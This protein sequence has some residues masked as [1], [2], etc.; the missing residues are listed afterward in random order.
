[1]WGLLALVCVG[2]THHHVQSQRPHDDFALFATGD[3]QPLVFR[4]EIIEPAIWR[5]NGSYRASDPTSEQWRTQWRV[6]C[7]AVRD[8]LEWRAAKCTSTLSVAGRIEELLPGDRIQV[9]GA[10]CAVHA[11]TNPGE[12][13]LRLFFAREQQF[14]F[15]RAESGKQIELLE[16]SWSRPVRRCIGIVV[17]H[18]DRV[19]CVAGSSWISAARGVLIFGQR[20]QVD[21]DEQQQLLSTGTLH[22]L[23]ISGMHVELVAGA[24]ERL[25]VARCR[26]CWTLV[27]VSTTVVLYGLISGAN[28]PVLCAVF[29]VLAACVARWS[30]K[31]SSMA[32]L[33]G[34]AGVMLLAMRT[35]W[36]ANVGVQ[37]SFLAVA[38]IGL[39][40]GV[41]DARGERVKALQLVEESWTWQRKLLAKLIVQ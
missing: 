7:T 5:P 17:Q 11:P 35:S 38:T 24:A 31:R 29:V 32:N 6:R 28:P 20:Q 21:W 19:S 12:G 3:Y 16:R 22:M 2:A 30:G 9:Y 41:V 25:F 40:A 4:A 13:D 15:L 26:S 37:L 36:M 39:Y 8:G 27:I 14:V 18:L 34:F 10:C 33:L 23:A 1:M